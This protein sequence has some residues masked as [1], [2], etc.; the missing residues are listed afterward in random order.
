MASLSNRKASSIASETAPARKEAPIGRRVWLGG[1]AAITASAL[2]RR[3][4]ARAPT[5]QKGPKEQVQHLVIGTGYG[6]SVAAYRLAKA[7]HRVL[8][9]EM[10]KRWSRPGADGKI[11][12]KMTK[13]DWRSMWYRD[14]LAMPLDRFL[15]LKVVN[16]KIGR[17][18]GVLDRRRLGEMDVFLGRGVGGGSLVNG[19]MAPRPRR[20]VIERELKSVNAE[21]FFDTYLPRAE[22][23]LGV[24][25]IRPEFYA[26]SKWYQYARTGERSARSVGYRTVDVPGTYDFRYME[27]EAQGKV[28]RSALAGQVILGNDH[29]KLDLTKTYLKYAEESGRVSIRTSHQATQIKALADGRYDVTVELKDFHWNTIET[30]VIRTQNLYLGAGSIGS[31]ELL[32]RSRALGGLANLSH[33]LGKH[34][35]PNGNTM[36][37]RANHI[38]DPTGMYQSTIPVRGVDLWDS[39]TPCFTEITPMPTGIETWCS[40]YLAVTDSPARAQ[41]SYSLSKDALSLDWTRSKSNQAVQ[42]AKAAFDRVNRKQATIY[43]SDFFEGGEKFSRNFCYHP[44]GGAA[45][46]R[47]TDAFGEV[48]GHPRLYLTD[49]SLIPGVVGV[50]PF[51]TITALAERLMDHVLAQG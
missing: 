23:R 19:A 25:S 20:S 43:R 45:L 50:N 28:P 14:R 31:T 40:M 48:R 24:S 1:A 4:H 9:L 49:A 18:P 35:G 21:R 42:I 37:A 26:T 12:T 47:V 34:W 29:G 5:L 2:A 39:D 30:F 7:G 33:E 27:L 17:G 13:P 51:L 11:F 44:L 10:G 22:K 3:A 32:M 8:M 36:F 16:P 38:W 46:G 6:G 15:G 41:F